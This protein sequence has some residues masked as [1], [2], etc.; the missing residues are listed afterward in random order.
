MWNDIETDDDLLNFSVVADA[1]ANMIIE[2]KFQPVSIGI[3]G[4]W[5]IGKSSMLKLIEKSIEAQKGA[6]KYICLTF[7]AWRY[8]GY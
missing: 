6:E 5:G 3:S 8:Q 2:N 7:D 1:A 4:S